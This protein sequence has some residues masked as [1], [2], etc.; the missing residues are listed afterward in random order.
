MPV[1]IRPT[2]R[3]SHHGHGRTF[4][5][6]S[7]HRP[8]PSRPNRSRPPIVE[9]PPKNTKYLLT[10]HHFC[11][12]IMVSI[13]SSISQ[14]LRKESSKEN[15]VSPSLPCPLK[16]LSFLPFL[17]KKLSEVVESE[18]C[19]SPGYN[20]PPEAEEVFRRKIRRRKIKI[21]LS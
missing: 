10:S 21:C 1:I 7:G 11:G 8:S 4:H 15:K 12:I 17:R 14:S 6:H 2:P 19:S 13:F 20:D 3:S 18:G 16:L 5:A 9:K